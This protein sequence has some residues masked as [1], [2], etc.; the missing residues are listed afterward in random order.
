MP[1]KNIYFIGYIASIL[2]QVAS[3]HYSYLLT[4]QAEV[5]NSFNVNLVFLL[6]PVRA[7]MTC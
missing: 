2:K 5:L 3:Y 4:L 7:N 1:I 6:F